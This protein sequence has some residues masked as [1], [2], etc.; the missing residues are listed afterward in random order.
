VLHG[1]EVHTSDGLQGQALGV[2]PS[3][4]L[5]LLQA[6]GERLIDSSEISVRPRP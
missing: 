6:A 1:R 5:R 4:A 3:G 2:G